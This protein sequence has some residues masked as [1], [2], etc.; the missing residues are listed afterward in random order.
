MSTNTSE[1]ENE[2]DTSSEFSRSGSPPPSACD[3]DATTEGFNDSKPE[4]GSMVPHDLLNED[5]S[6]NVN[7]TTENPMADWKSNHSS[8]STGSDPDSSVRSTRLDGR[9]TPVV[10]EEEDD[11]ANQAS[12]L[13]S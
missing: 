10:E 5:G 12:S 3:E 13:Q 7:E 4:Q 8:T 1:P 9:L 6:Q 2:H 11:E